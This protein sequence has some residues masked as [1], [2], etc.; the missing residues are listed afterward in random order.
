M[1]GAKSTVSP[2]GMPQTA[3][4]AEMTAEANRILQGVKTEARTSAQQV[5]LLGR[6][7]KKIREEM[8]QRQLSKLRLAVLRQEAA[9][10]R[11]DLDHALTSV[12]AQI[13]RANAVRP[14]VEIIANPG[15]PVRPVF[16]NPLLALLG[17]LMAGCL[18]GTAMN[19]RPI[20]GWGRRV[21]EI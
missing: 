21:L 20:A 10:D 18:A 7:I 13:G 16:P 5:I 3:F 2:V 4:D 11:R 8:T 17:T 6:E 15:V 19:W 9:A 12:R 1:S 14:D